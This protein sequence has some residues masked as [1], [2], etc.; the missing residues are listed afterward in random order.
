MATT[1]HAQAPSPARGEA[2][3]RPFRV[4]FLTSHPIQYQAPLFRALAAHPGVDLTVLFCSD[5]GLTAYRDA[6]FGHEV[7]W[8]VPLVEGYAHEF[9]PNRARKADVEGFWGQVNPAVVGR[10][11]DGRWDALIVHG[12]A[13]ATNLMAIAAAR[14]AGVPV[15]LRGENN[16]LPKVSPKKQRVRAAILP[17][18]FGRAAGFLAIG[19]YNA[20]FYRAFGAPADRV[21]VA[22]YAVDNARFLEAADSLASRKDEL[23][24]E[25]G[26]DPALPVVLFSGKLTPVK[27]PMDLLQAFQ[28]ARA[29]HPAALVFLGDGALR[30]ELEAYVRDQAIPD[31]VFAGF[32]NQSELPRVFAAADAFVLP[33]GFERWGL[34]VNEALCFGL[35]VIASDQVGSTGDLVDEGINGFVFPAGDVDALAESIETLIADPDLRARMGAASRARIGTWGFD[36]DVDAVLACLRK[37]ARGRD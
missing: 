5:W 19:R 8:D 10:I 27:R 15:I 32:R 18:L 11:R 1:T 37:V 23:K 12:W 34:V 36:Q 7:R 2:A 22:P 6:G 4:A 17:R 29:K 25:L 9:L 16:L 35:P 20:E 13:K 26:I 21:F 28:R 24:R 30:G 3:G 31:V 14:S 33:S